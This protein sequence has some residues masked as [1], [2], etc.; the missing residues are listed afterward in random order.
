MKSAGPKMTQS[1]SIY[2]YGIEKRHAGIIKSTNREMINKSIYN[3]EL[4]N[5]IYFCWENTSHGKQ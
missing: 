1:S 3:L 5:R 2:Q 4:D